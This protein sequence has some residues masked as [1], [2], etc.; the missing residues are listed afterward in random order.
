MLLIMFLFIV[1]IMFKVSIHSDVSDYVP[2]Y[3][4]VSDDVS[5][6]SYVSDYGSALLLFFHDVARI[7]FIQGTP[8]Y[9]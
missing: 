2:I 1:L 5:I 7:L 8:P 4:H 9:D 3:S 6:H